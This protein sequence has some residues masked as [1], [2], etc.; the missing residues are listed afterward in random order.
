MQTQLP[1][2][3]RA[4][5]PR[6]VTVHCR[7]CRGQ[8]VTRAAAVEWSA[9]NQ[10]W[11]VVGLEDFTECNDCQDECVTVERDAATGKPASSLDLF[12]GETA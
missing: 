2:V 5:S 4:I 3:P 9:A 11:L 10:A 7:K 6:P 12:S 1:E 8:N